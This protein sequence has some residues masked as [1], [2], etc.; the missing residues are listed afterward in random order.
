MP[1]AVERRRGELLIAEDLHPLA[2]GEVG[3]DDRRAP[4][5]AVGEQ[6]EEQFSAGPLEGHEA[7]FVDDQ[8]RDA[9]VAPVERAERVLVPRLD[10]VAYEVGGADEGDAVAAAGGLAAERDRE[11]RLAGADRAR[12]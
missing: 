6:V 5:V 10:E 3:G 12:R 9:Q 4:L 11:V 7:E 1:E 8:Q 2:E